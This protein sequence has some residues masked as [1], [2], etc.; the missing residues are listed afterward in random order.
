M[1]KSWYW[2]IWAEFT[3]LFDISWLLLWFHRGWRTTQHK[4]WTNHHAL[5]STVCP[6]WYPWY[7]SFRQW[8]PVLKRGICTICEFRNT[9]LSDKLG[10]PV[11]RL[12]GRRTKNTHTHYWTTADSK[13]YKTQ[14][15]TAQT[16]KKQK[17]T[18]ALLWQSCKAIIK[19]KCGRSRVSATWWQVE[20]SRRDLGF[21]AS[22]SLLLHHHTAG[23]NLPEKQT[24]H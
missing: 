24:T 6:L 9:P 13:D 11:Q 7:L 19:A 16:Y 10:S 14:S 20:A 1:G 21:S 3:Q 2:P 22:T 18:K 15:S 8:T 17:E 5:Q 4:E 23:S 12:M